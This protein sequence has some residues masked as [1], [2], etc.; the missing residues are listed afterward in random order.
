MNGFV[1]ILTFLAI[2]YVFQCLNAL[3]NV[4]EKEYKTKRQVW[5]ALIPIV[6]PVWIFI[7]YLQK[8]KRNYSSLN[9][10]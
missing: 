2:C 9:E 5:V 1:A 7:K 8:V 4:G 6:Y 10:N 3:L